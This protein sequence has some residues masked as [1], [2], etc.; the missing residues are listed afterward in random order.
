MSAAT[1]LVASRWFDDSHVM[2]SHLRHGAALRRTIATVATVTALIAAAPAAAQQPDSM[3]A[4]FD[5]VAIT[6]DWH[7]G[8]ALGT[9][10]MTGPVGDAGTAR[11]A[12]RRVGQHIYATAT[13]IGAHGILTLGLRATMTETF[14]GRQSAAGH[15]STCGGTGPY[16]RVAGAGDWS[17]A[18][19]VLEAPTGSLPQALHG[20]YS[21]R[22]HRRST[23]RRAGFIS[24]RDAHC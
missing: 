16:R 18:F 5:A 9:F 11:I 12:Y 17:A 7:S 20:A 23:L 15:W 13:L 14:D 10:A 2:D 21:G 6:G 22:I 19:D 3:T 4:N 8:Q 24:S 1:P